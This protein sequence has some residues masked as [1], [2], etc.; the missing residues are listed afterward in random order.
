LIKPNILNQIPATAQLLTAEIRLKCSLVGSGIYTTHE[1][2]E[3]WPENVTWGGQPNYDPTPIETLNINGV[4]G[5]WYMINI[6]SLAPD[7]LVG[8]KSNYGILI[9]SDES[10]VD[11]ISFC[12]SNHSNSS[13]YPVYYFEYIIKKSKK[14]ILLKQGQGGGIL[15]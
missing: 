15:L 13:N 6:L 2:L 10:S 1:V 11:N 8:F 14:G 9:K 3:S 4:V 7:W 5:Q 12:S